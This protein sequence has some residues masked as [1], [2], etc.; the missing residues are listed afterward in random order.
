[1]LA[2]F[3]LVESHFYCNICQHLGSG[4]AVNPHLKEEVNVEALIQKNG[5]FLLKAKA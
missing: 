4:H 2:I 3:A 1:M 5:G